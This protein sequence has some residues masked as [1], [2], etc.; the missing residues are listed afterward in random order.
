MLEDKN[1][2]EN[3]KENDVENVVED[4]VEDEEKGEEKEEDKTQASGATVD[5]NDATNTI[6]Q[7][8]LKQTEP[9][10]IPVSKFYPDGIYPEGE[11][12][13]YK[14]DNLKRITNEEKRNLD[15]ML[16]DGY[17]DIRRAA[18]VHR[19]VRK[20][21]QKTI[22]PGMTMI[23]IC[24]L[25]EN[26]TRLLIEENGLSA[27]IGFP[28]G[29]SLNNFAAHYTPNSGDKTVLQYDDVCK[30]D[31]GTHVNGRI[32]DSAFTLAFN[33]VYDNLKASVKDA[34]NTGVKEAGIDVRLG[35][36]GAAIQE[37]MES[38]EVEI[39]GKTQQVKPIRNLHGHSI[40]PYQIHGG[41]SVPIVK[42]GDQ[43]KMEEGEYFAIETFGSTGKGVVH[44]DGECSHYAKRQNLGHIP[45]RV[46]RT[47]ALLNSISKNF[48]TL[49]F[50]R[51][52]LDR[53]GET[54]YALAL[55]NLV[56]AGAVES[57]PPLV[58]I[59]GSYTAQYEHTI[60]LRPTCKEIPYLYK[61]YSSNDTDMKGYLTYYTTYVS[62][63]QLEILKSLPTDSE[64]KG[65]IH[66][67]YKQ[68]TALAK[69]LMMKD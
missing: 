28:T 69:I 25:I 49:P 19:Q 42:N 10:T 9:P 60:V 12:C 65:I 54:K 15:R 48:G 30:I 41:K 34:T 5:N 59:K 18:E 14:N 16:F 13:E 26:S 56:D 11:I 20:H 1:A 51:R 32:I 61:V 45:L 36:I 31:F 22:K 53:V 17:N 8:E 39:N 57:Y 40:L 27:G 62:L 6:A 43:T 21:A 63:N 50:C 52:Y 67:A 7:T 24:E 46:A 3:A 37:V 35:D 23:E 2:K 66:I 47:K 29:C 55:K 33:P 38:Y 44:E 64:I 58:D 4:V 68:A